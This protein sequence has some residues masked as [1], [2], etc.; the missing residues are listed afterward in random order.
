MPLFRNDVGITLARTSRDKLMSVHCRFLTSRVA[1]YYPYIRDGIA[2]GFL[3]KRK[4]GRTY[5][6]RLYIVETKLA[7]LLMSEVLIIL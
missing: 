7:K 1:R 5:F 4:D 6:M 3:I 2:P